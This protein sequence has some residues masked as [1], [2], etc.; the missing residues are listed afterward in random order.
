MDIYR[1]QGT[2]ESDI[3]YNMSKRIE[4]LVESD[5]PDIL[6]R[7]VEFIIKGMDLLNELIR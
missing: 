2:H 3:T 7:C 5:L 1:V 4:S 6:S